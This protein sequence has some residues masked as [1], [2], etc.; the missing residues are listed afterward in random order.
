LNALEASHLQ[1]QAVSEFFDELSGQMDRVPGVLADEPE[2][3][4]EEHM[5]SAT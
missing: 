2:H 1:V 5:E 4:E 3:G